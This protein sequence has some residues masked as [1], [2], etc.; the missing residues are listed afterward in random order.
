MTMIQIIFEYETQYGVFRDALHL[1]ED[2]G[3]SDA[4]L[5]AMKQERVDNWLAVVTPKPVDDEVING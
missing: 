4:Q 3:L 1:P 2:H 5:A